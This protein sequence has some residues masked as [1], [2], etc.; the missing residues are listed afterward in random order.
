MIMTKYQRGSQAD[1]DFLTKLSEY[2]ELRE[3]FEANKYLKQISSSLV[4]FFKLDDSIRCK[5][6][7]YFS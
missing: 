4:I 2:P 7:A 3:R 5:E 6:K 1:E